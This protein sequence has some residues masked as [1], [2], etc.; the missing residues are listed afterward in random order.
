MVD[1]DVWM[2]ARFVICSVLVA[3]SMIEGIKDNLLMGI[4]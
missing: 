4:F 3:D 1:V 2:A